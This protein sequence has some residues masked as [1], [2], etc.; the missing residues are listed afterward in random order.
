M[1]HFIIKFIFIYV[2]SMIPSLLLFNRGKKRLGTF[3]LLIMAFLI[4][5][6][7]W[8]HSD[9][10]EKWFLAFALIIW[11]AQIS[12]IIILFIKIKSQPLE[13]PVIADIQKMSLASKVERLGTFIYDIVFMFVFLAVFMI[14]MQIIF[15]IF[16]W[17]DAFD[18]VKQFSNKYEHLFIMI[19]LL[20]YYVP[21]EVFFGKTVGKRIMK[22]KVVNED[23]SEL[24]WTSAIIRT[25]CRLI[26]LDPFSFIFPFFISDLSRPIGWHDRI[27]KTKVISYE[28]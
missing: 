23:G 12:Y 16:S 21:Q 28:I 22:T 6:P 15:Q 24:K 11:L 19:L 5:S 2:I 14:F 25:L 10:I 8:V 26:P 18:T 13:V 20:F 9:T 4:I 7:F 3:L 17:G 1:I 27:S